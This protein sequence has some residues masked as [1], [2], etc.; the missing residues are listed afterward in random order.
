MLQHLMPQSS[1]SIFNPTP[2]QKHQLQ[3]ALTGS[4]M[5]IGELKY[6][7]LI[8]PI[9]WDNTIKS[10]LGYVRTSP[11]LNEGNNYQRANAIELPLDYKVSIFQW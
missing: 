7:L 2:S 9:K 11:S 3:S 6:T 8:L 4:T 5:A 10:Q 1:Y